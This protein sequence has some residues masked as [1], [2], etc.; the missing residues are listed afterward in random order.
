MPAGLAV[1]LTKSRK[2]VQGSHALKICQLYGFYWQSL[3]G[4]SD[5]RK[6][7]MVSEGF[8]PPIQSVE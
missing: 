7:R 6:K 2:G 4:L 3:K 5:C 8:G 1:G